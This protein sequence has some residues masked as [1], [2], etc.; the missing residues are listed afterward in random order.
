MIESLVSLSH[1]NWI[2]FFKYIL[3]LALVIITILIWTKSLRS[4]INGLFITLKDYVV[5]MTTK[6]LGAGSTI[7]NILH[8]VWTKVGITILMILSIVLSVYLHI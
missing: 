7:N 8:S 3:P 2:N 4:Y 6:F 1:M 5:N